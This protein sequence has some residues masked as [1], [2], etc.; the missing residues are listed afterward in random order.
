[1]L[2]ISAMDK[3]ENTELVMTMRYDHTAPAVPPL[4]SGTKSPIVVMTH[5]LPKSSEYP[6]MDRKRKFLYWRQ[7]SPACAAR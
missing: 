5:P 4:V 3:V 1:M 6:K 7:V 2:A